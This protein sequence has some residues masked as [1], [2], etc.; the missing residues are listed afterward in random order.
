VRLLFSAALSLL[1]GCA[2]PTEAVSP[3]LPFDDDDSG[4][5][6]SPLVDLDVRIGRVDGGAV[7]QGSPLRLTTLRVDCAAG[8]DPDVDNEDPLAEATARWLVTVDVEGWASVTDPARLFLWEGIPD[9]DLAT[10][11]LAWP[12]RA[13]MTQAPSG[14]SSE[15]FGH[16]RWV[17]SVPVFDD[18][19][20]ADT[21]G[22]T[23]L[24]CLDSSGEPAPS[25][26]DV[27]VCALDARDL[28]TRHCWFCGQHM[29]QPSSTAGDT[30][31]RIGVTGVPGL[32]ALTVTAEVVC[33]YG[34]VPS[35][36][37]R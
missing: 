13:A 35:E 16:D 11:R 23:T 30:V 7:P 37:G 26:H 31:G 14:A 19:T 21:V 2:A 24:D 15:P 1:V 17:Q 22:G 8:P 20:T 34:P 28:E 9:P 4:T 29:G 12:G 18:P 36:R 27:M 5:E 32:P 10:H 33:A 6:E 25:V 3:P